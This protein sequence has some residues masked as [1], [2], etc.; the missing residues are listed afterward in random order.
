MYF[1]RRLPLKLCC[2]LILGLF[3][4][5]WCNQARA[6]STMEVYM[7]VAE[8]MEISFLPAIPKIYFVE[9]D[10]LQTAFKKGNRASYQ[11]WAAEFGESQARRMMDQYLE[12]IVGLFVP[13]S[14]TIYVYEYLPPCRRQ[15]VLAHEICHFF[16]NFTDGVI[17][18]DQYGADT[19]HLVREME[20]YQ[21]EKK[22]TG[23]HCA[24]GQQ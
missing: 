11:R 12:G 18:R 5:A 23:E 20:A 19:L 4:A 16:Q 21:I 14:E 24:A 3:L 1:I 8:K 22:Y 17:K 6:D 13:D 10:Q 2:T 7:W 15:A 9:K